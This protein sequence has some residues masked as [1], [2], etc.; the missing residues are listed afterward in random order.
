MKL[1]LVFD[2]DGTLS[3]PRKGIEASIRFAFDALGRSLDPA[4][5]LRWCIGPPL[6]ASLARLLGPG[7]ASLAP[8]ALRLYRQRY[9]D[10]GLY[11]NHVYDGIHP[12]LDLL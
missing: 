1:S 7:Q 9:A 10:I 2:L 3:D 8:E 4:L 5:D 6:L 12:A 11:E